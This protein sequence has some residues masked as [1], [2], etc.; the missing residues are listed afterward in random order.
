[1]TCAVFRTAAGDE[2]RLIWRLLGIVTTDRGKPTHRL[3]AKNVP[4]LQLIKLISVLISMPP[5][6]LVSQHEVHIFLL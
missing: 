6:A 3:P 4:Y 5:S 2:Y 1:M